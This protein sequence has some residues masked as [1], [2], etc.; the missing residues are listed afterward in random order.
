[1]IGVGARSRVD[2]NE[3]V[4]PM[5]SPGTGTE[6]GTAAVGQR[7]GQWLGNGTPGSK[8]NDIFLQG[9]RIVG[10]LTQSIL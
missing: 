10:N 6:A 1:M 2:G 8:A 3:C 9:C 4:H 7:R 5:A